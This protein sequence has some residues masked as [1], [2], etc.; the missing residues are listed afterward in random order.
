MST[1]STLE[2]NLAARVATISVANG[3]LTDIGARVFRGK[4]KLDPSE[5]PCTVAVAGDNNV[6]DGKRRQVKVSQRYIFEGHDVCDPDQPNAK[7]HQIIADLKKAFFAGDLTFGGI[8]RPDDLQYVGSTIGTREDGANLVAA[9]I[10]V[11]CIFVEELD[12]P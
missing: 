9:S 10:E 3:Y 2:E 4:L 6:M 7:A 5:F 12:N 11:D 8:M 1:A